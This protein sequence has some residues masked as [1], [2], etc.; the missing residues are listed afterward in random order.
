M[1]DRDEFGAFL[2]GFLVG[3][4][5]G[6]VTALLLAPQSGS[7]TRTLIRDRAIELKDKASSTVDEAYKQAESAALDARSKFDDLA[8]MTKERAQELK[9]QGVLILEEQKGKITDALS[10]KTDKPAKSSGAQTPA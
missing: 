4:V 8:K 1:S 9:S 7:E 5:T 6:A 2:I 3:G 10:K